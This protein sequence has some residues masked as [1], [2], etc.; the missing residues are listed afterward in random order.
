MSAG[1]RA[2]PRRRLAAVAGL[3]AL[4]VGLAGAPAADA[5]PR[6]GTVTQTSFGTLRQGM[7]KKQVRARWGRATFARAGRPWSTM[8]YG[9]GKGRIVLTFYRGRFDDATTRLRGFRFRGVG[10]GMTWDAARAR[11]PAIGCNFSELDAWPSGCYYGSRIAPRH[12]IYFV[13]PESGPIQR[14]WFVTDHAS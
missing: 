6:S 8:T 10:V 12:E 2:R 3:V 1:T 4:L 13:G 5:Y 14:I 9:R 11:I 7:T